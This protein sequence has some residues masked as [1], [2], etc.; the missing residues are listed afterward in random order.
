MSAKSI[1]LIGVGGIGTH[2]LRAFTNLSN[3]PKIVV[4]T[5]SESKE[6]PLL[7]DDLASVPVVPVDYAD[8]SALTGVLKAHAVDVIISTVPMPA[9]E[10][11][12]YALADAAKAAGSVKLFAP[13][14][15][16]IPTEG[17]K[18]RGEVSWFAVKDEFVEY[19]KSIEMPYTRFYIGF[20]M[21]YV[22]WLTGMDVT[23]SVH[24]VG[25]GEELLT[26]TSETDAGG[27][28]AH[29][30]TNY[31]LTSPKLVNQSLRLKGQ[32]V[33]LREAA[34]IYSKPVVFIP[35]G[36]QI[37]ARS[38]RELYLKTVLQTEA[39][40]GRLNTGWDRRTWTYD[41]ELEGSAN[42]LWDGHVWETLESTIGQT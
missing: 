22:P 24:V 21:S 34:Q 25:T 42:K 20:G 30:L 10:K 1:A 8:V 28:T 13:S 9:G 15:W 23:D 35:E 12:Q 19:L 6:K 41:P 26:L 40:G 2:I 27:F 4:F 3:G 18:E 5:R 17:A 38:E 36:G 11:A 37:P 39:A 32:T 29:V 7:P 14:E 33:T 31:S 16:G